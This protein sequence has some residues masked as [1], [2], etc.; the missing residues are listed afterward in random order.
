M[1]TGR[2]YRG[3][4]CRSSGMGTLRTKMDRAH[5]PWLSLFTFSLTARPHVT[6]RS[7]VL[8]ARLNL[9]TG[10]NFNSYKSLVEMLEWLK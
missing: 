3:P 1:E 6:L 10:I 2:L 5:T 8:P 4:K 7:Q 9:Q